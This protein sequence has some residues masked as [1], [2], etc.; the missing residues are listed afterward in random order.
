M[1]LT[2][3]AEA[4]VSL[5]RLHVLLGVQSLNVVLVSVNRLGPW[6]TGFV[7]PNE[8]L[9]WVDLINMLIVP[10]ISVICSWLIK[11][12]LERGIRAG[13]PAAHA[14]LALTFV[15]GIYLLGAGYGAHEVTNYLHVR[16][17]PRGDELA[18]CGIVAFNDDEFSHWVWF[19][20]FIVMTA[21]LMGIQAL[22]PYRDR[23]SAAD[24]GLLIFNGLFIALGIFANAAFEEIGLDLYV[25]ALIAG[26]ALVL[27]RLR[28]A[29]PLLVYNAVAFG[30]GLAATVVYKG[31]SAQ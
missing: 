28:R 5:A 10:L 24:A 7:A 2:Q 29:Q 17:C 25:V 13:S 14:V 30:V 8:F 19:A 12:D 18:L 23:L 4:R 1:V 21:A 20:G 27:M 6:T 16:F 9:R 26:I 3:R 31:L 15:I 22:F 11:R